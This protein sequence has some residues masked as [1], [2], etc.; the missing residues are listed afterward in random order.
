MLNQNVLKCK[1]GGE[2]DDDDDGDADWCIHEPRQKTAAQRRRLRLRERPADRPRPRPTG[3]AV[4]LSLPLPFDELPSPHAAAAAPQP[5]SAAAPDAHVLR[6]LSP[7]SSAVGAAAAAAA[8]MMECQRSK[9]ERRKG[10]LLSS[11]LLCNRATAND[12]T[13]IRSELRTHLLPVRVRV[14]RRPER[15]RNRFTHSRRRLRGVGS[16]FG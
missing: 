8:G 9:K 15:G 16:L 5:A 3:H 14:R 7:L 12:A 6:T 1:R 4:S 2:E 13:G 11:P 10:K